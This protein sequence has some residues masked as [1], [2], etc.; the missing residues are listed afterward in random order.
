MRRLASPP[1]KDEEPLKPWRSEPTIL[2]RILFTVAM[3]HSVLAKPYALK[4]C[5]VAAA[6]WHSESKTSGMILLPLAMT[7]SVF[8][9]SKRC[10]VAAVAWHSKWKAS[11]P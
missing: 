3:A 4:A 9:A 1:E 8:C 6:A 7:S 2:G 11:W 5:T 10:T